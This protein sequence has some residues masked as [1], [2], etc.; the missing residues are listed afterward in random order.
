MRWPFSFEA[1]NPPGG[2]AGR[3]TAPTIERVEG[4]A[5]TEGLSFGSA[6]ALKKWK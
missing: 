3:L 5:E 2:S 1:G 6:L 4:V